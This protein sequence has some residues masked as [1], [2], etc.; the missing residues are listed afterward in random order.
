MEEF[1]S[2]DKIV[3]LFRSVNCM[4]NENCYFICYKDTT[5]EGMKAGVIGGAI[6]G[7]GLIG[8][9]IASAVMSANS[10]NVSIL[11]KFDGYLINWT[12][13]GVGIIP[14]K[15]QGK[16]VTLN[17]SKMHPQMD[18]F[19][20]IPKENLESVVVKN[21]NI[22]NSKVKKIKIKIAGID[23]KLELMANVK[24]KLI[25]YQE[26]NFAKFLDMYNR[27]YATKKQ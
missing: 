25:P 22:F 2:L 24:E 3:Y 19:T 18:S 9:A 20:Y 4:G 11:E 12:D 5:A 10:G 7:A 14:L 27:T 6:G 13:F 16:M 1:N 8:G 15:Y 26:S 21:F 17:P 23:S